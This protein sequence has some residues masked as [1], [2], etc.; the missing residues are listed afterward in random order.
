MSSPP[1]LALPPPM[2]D[3][4][5][6]EVVFNLDGFEEIEE[7]ECDDYDEF[8]DELNAYLEDIRFELSR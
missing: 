1:F 5:V 7:T 6:D 4:T 2:I 3:Y 8:A